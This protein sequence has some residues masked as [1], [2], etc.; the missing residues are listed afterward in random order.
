MTYFKNYS[1]QTIQFHPKFNVLVGLNGMG[2]TNILD[3]IYYCCLGK[4]YFSS[5]DKYSVSEGQDFF[6]IEA[7][8][9]PVNKNKPSV[10]IKNPLMGKKVIEL[11]GVKINKLSEFIGF[12]PGVMIVPSDI[13]K[14]LEG[15]EERR[16]FLNN[17]IVQ[18]QQGYL[19]DLLKYNAIVKQRNA[20]LKANY[21]NKHADGRVLDALTQP[22]YTLNASIYNN[23]QKWMTQLEPFFQDTYAKISNSKE[24]V[25]LTY[26][27]EISNGDIIQSF[28]KSLTK[29]KI[30]GRTNYGIHRDDLDMQI[31]GRPI[32]NFASQGQI[33]SFILSL[34][35]AQYLLLREATS[36]LPLLLLDDIFDKLDM[37][38]VTYL[39]HML[40]EPNFGQ[41]FITDTGKDRM[42][43]IFHSIDKEFKIFNVE[44]GKI[45]L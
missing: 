39:L 6:R 23:R 21:D 5:S 9:Q 11:N 32:K 20:W 45:L 42:A 18:C 36:A 19:D 37:S 34:K 22:L 15:S 13:Y 17:T 29:D 27:S 26:I 41:I 2:K 16:N 30:L 1:S 12:C 35:L 43:S 7:Q 14:M 33:K 25:S 4:S 40:C 24:S 44:D 10:V 31:D 3:A 28:E 8:F 38:R